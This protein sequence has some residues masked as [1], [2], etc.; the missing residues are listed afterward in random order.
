LNYTVNWRNHTKKELWMSLKLLQLFMVGMVFFAWSI[1][2]AE[3]VGTIERFEALLQVN[4]GQLITLNPEI[5][6]DDWSAVPGDKITLTLKIFKPSVNESALLRIW[7]PDPA[8]V[9]IEAISNISGGYDS[10]RVKNDLEIRF[11]NFKITNINEE[12]LIRVSMHVKDGTQ[13]NNVCE[14]RSVRLFYIYDNSNPDN[15]YYKNPSFNGLI[16]RDSIKMV[17]DSVKQTG[18]PCDYTD[19]I[20]VR[21]FYHFTYFNNSDTTMQYTGIMFNLFCYPYFPNVNDR[22]INGNLL[23]NDS[24]LYYYGK[25]ANGLILNDYK[26]DM[27]LRKIGNSRPGNLDEITLQGSRIDSILY[28]AP[29]QIGPISNHTIYDSLELLIPL[30]GLRQNQSIVKFCAPDQIQV[31]GTDCAF[32]NPNWDDCDS[33]VIIISNDSLD[34]YIS[35]FNIQKLDSAAVCHHHGD[36][37]KHTILYGKRYPWTPLNPRFSIVDTLPRYL[38]FAY[39]EYPK[40]PEPQAQLSAVW[41]GTALNW[42]FLIDS[43]DF[44]D[45]IVF[46]TTFNSFGGSIGNDTM[47][48]MRIAPAN[49]YRDSLGCLIVD[50]DSNNYQQAKILSPMLPR[51]VDLSFSELSFDRECYGVGDTL[52]LNYQLNSSTAEVCSVWI[53]ILLPSCLSLIDH[54]VRDSVPGFNDDIWYYWKGSNSDQQH[55]AQFLFN[56]NCGSE[57]QQLIE[58]AVMPELFY[59]ENGNCMEVTDSNPTNDSSYIRFEICNVPDFSIEKHCEQ[60]AYAVGDTARFTVEIRNLSGAVANIQSVTVIDSL[61]EKSADQINSMVFDPPYASFGFGEIP[62]TN[63]FIR[64]ADR[65][66][67]VDGQFS[68]RLPLDQTLYRYGE[69]VVCH[70][71]ATVIYTDTVISKTDTTSCLV[72]NDCR[73]VPNPFTPNDDTKND[74]TWFYPRL[75][76]TIYIYDIRGTR[77]RSLPMS[78]LEKKWD[79]MDDNGRPMPPGL[80]VWE[81]IENNLVRCNG[82]VTL[83]R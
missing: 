49:V 42:T 43:A 2:H 73:A 46:Y 41:N 38:Q 55:S 29:F 18:D 8:D 31:I 44:Q 10:L 15:P 30:E 63:T 16:T 69:R 51:E 28:Q 82:T 66:R 26:E 37:L 60:S 9:T 14:G 6:A 83:V 75:N 27:V 35:D 48:V 11:D 68:Y 45:S 78:D 33:A 1:I 71:S 40:I 61:P 62:D 56:G 52:Q 23:V 34:Y 59:E 64:Q 22:Y 5:P 13:I 32:S 4:G 25:S 21:V 74:Y 58:L 39:Q 81:I 19:Y 24:M 50:P 80:Y 70:V 67:Q 54:F 7:M 3:P 17:I 36:T 20:P 76:T 72:L 53:S 12:G 77:V 57:L 47:D 79:G 65:G